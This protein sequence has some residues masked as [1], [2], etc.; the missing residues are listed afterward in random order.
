MPRPE[1]ST[2]MKSLTASMKLT[3][4]ATYDKITPA[5]AGH[6]FRSDSCRQRPFR[7]VSTDAARSGPPA[8]IPARRHRIRQRPFRSATAGSV[9]LYEDPRPAKLGSHPGGEEH[10]FGWP[11]DLDAGRGNQLVLTRNQLRPVQRP[12]AVDVGNIQGPSPEPGVQTEPGCQMEGQRISCF[13]VGLRG[14]RKIG[15]R[16]AAEPSHPVPGRWATPALRAGRTRRSGATRKPGRTRRS[17]ATRKPGRPP[18][19]TPPP[20][21]DPRQ[22]KDPNAPHP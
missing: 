19:E 14:D 13:D 7:S 3:L 4:V 11:R 21:P 12:R 22:P 2:A 6:R 16:P 1:S 20:L 5:T 15:P 8:P 17:G 10:R 9:P 18:P